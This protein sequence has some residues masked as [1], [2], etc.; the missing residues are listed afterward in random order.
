MP[1]PIDTAHLRAIKALVR[2]QGRE[3]LTHEG[4]LRVAHDHGLE[5]IQTEL[6]H[7]DAEARSAVVRAVASGERGT[8]SGLGDASP[9]NV[10][11]HL[12]GATLRMAETRA[13]NRAL[14]LYTGLG[15][16]TTEELPG[17]HAAAPGRRVELPAA[18]TDH[19]PPVDSCGVCGRMISAEQARSTEQ[20]HG[21]ALCVPHLEVWDR[22]IDPSW[23]HDRLAFGD[24]IAE[25][26]LDYRPLE[27]R[28]VASPQWGCRPS[29]MSPE[30]RARLLGVL[31]QHRERQGTAK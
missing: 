22:P 20:R 28:C 7:W 11:R 14:R 2:L 25:L 17:D 1:G 23:D 29:Q 3:Y 30:Q 27:T 10:A 24:A 16:T 18:L 8:Y 12:Q 19:P 4:L 31:R 26:G 6:I 21:V 13:V 9:A 5:S 15:T